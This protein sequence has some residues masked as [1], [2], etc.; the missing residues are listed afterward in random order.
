M[1]RLIIFDGQIS[2]FFIELP[3]NCCNF[4]DLINNSS[5]NMTPY[6]QTLSNGLRVI[7]LPSPTN[8][9]YCG[10]TVNT[11]TRDEMPEELGM[12]HFIEHM[13]FKG[14]KKRKAWHILNRME[15]VGGELN[16]YT[17]KEDT[18]FYTSC[19]SR[20]FE[21]AVELLSDIVFNGTFPQNEIEKEVGVILDEIKSYEDNPSELIFDEF[22]GLLFQGDSLGNS[23]LGNA[24]TLKSFG[25]A[26]A[27][28]FKNRHYQ[29]QNM[30][31][32]VFGGLDTKKIIRI[33]QKHLSGERPTFNCAR[34]RRPV[35]VYKP[36][37]VVTNKET[38]Q[39]HVMIG[40][41][42]YMETN[43]DRMGLY[44]LNNMLGGPGMN[45]RLNI[46][47]REKKGLVYSAESNVTSY[48]DTGVFCIYFG[49]DFN[50][51]DRCVS[52]SLKELKNFCDNTLSEIR[53]NAAKKQLIG[54][55]GVSS[56]SFENIALGMGKKFLH[57]GYYETSQELFKK[58]DNLTPSQLLRI[59]NEI[60]NPD[61][62]TTLIYR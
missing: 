11:G 55:I 46:T 51:I 37:T 57:N 33:A 58:I 3:N 50:D 32:F 1:H 2:V 61:N 27:L 34:L 16:A 40:V 5:K 28:K 35:S 4:A 60:F 21:R 41:R 29:P 54:Q 53:L 14:T 10:F 26:D 24:D 39:A 31:F 6:I 62:L 48:S 7:C 13:A 43:P 42:G 18:V 23:I 59:A 44:L 9:V 38:H 15:L 20:D 56:D 8:V 36:K 12:A 19:L 49:C 17:T 25:T 45:S 47:L 22:E 30:V 52:L